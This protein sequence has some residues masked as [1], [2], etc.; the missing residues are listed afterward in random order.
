[1]MGNVNSVEEF[2]N[3]Y[4]ARMLQM[5]EKN[6]QANCCYTKKVDEASTAPSDN[7]VHLGEVTTSKEKKQL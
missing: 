5:Q 2:T 7:F 1:M 4:M 6:H 3:L